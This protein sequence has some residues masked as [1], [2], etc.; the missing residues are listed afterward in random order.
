MTLPAFL[1]GVCFYRFLIDGCETAS[2]SHILFIALAEIISKRNCL[3]QFP[4][5]GFP[6][7]FCLNFSTGN[8]PNK[9]TFAFCST[10][11]ANMGKPSPS[12]E[13]L[14]DYGRGHTFSITK[15][16]EDVSFF[17]WD[18]SFHLHRR[19]HFLKK[20]FHA[21]GNQ[22]FMRWQKHLYKHIKHVSSSD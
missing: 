2:E 3:T 19:G 16:S 15:S 4:L 14:Y 22:T 6:K 17:L 18:Y 7:G 5:R 1:S 20:L 12:S 10:W 9:T 21:W 8:F 13:D 11:I